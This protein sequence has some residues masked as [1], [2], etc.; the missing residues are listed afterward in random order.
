MGK[1]LTLS[2][3]IGSGRLGDFIA[4]AEAEGVAAADEAELERPGERT[5]RV[6]RSARK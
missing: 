1:P 3:A 6:R 4:Q 2:E 5:A